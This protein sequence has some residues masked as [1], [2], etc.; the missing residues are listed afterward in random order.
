[1]NKAKFDVVCEESRN[2][3]T[4]QY[5]EIKSITHLHRE[6]VKHNILPKEI[7]SQQFRRWFSEMRL[8][9]ESD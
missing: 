4:G 5:P 1:M 2:Y 3:L 7:T 8:E 6:L 9:W